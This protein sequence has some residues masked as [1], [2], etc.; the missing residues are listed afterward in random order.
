MTNL[1]QL[2]HDD[3]K[4]L[5]STR[6]ATI[7]SAGQYAIKVLSKDFTVEPHNP[8]FELSILARLSKKRDPHVIQLIDSRS[9]DDELE[10]LFPRY[11]MDLNE[12]MRRDYK[13]SFSTVNPYYTLAT[14]SAAQSEGGYRNK[15]DV[16]RYALDFTLQLARGLEF[17]HLNDIIHRDIKPQN[18]LVAKDRRD[19]I[20]LIITDFGIS[21]DCKDPQQLS[22]EP[23]DNKI[24]DVSTSVYKA[25]E[26]LFGVKNYTFAIDIWA[27]MV[28]ISQWFQT[29][30][31]NP[32]RHIPAMF[33]DG[34]GLF[35]DG[36]SGSDIKLIL[37]I[38]DQLGIPSIKEWPEVEQ[39][40][41]CDAF[42]GMFGSEGDSQYILNKP[43]D[44]KFKKIN[45]LLP[46][47]NEICDPKK[48][49]ALRSC[50]LGMMSFESSKRCTSG[51][52]VKTLSL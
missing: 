5:K 28:M 1:S 49:T 34:S 23:L 21:Y 4:L 40:G 38:F 13:P 39:N 26:L 8:N 45:N 20:A 29:K 3:R 18:I 27:L 9:V 48:R 42:C 25:P 52:I 17:L 51:D 47:L 30:T 14:K 7:Y 10:L 2:A 24:T 37:S 33:E 12:L 31:N 46:R 6:F 19:S 16:D 22:L 15:F 36:E 11:Q 43:E 41:S 44:D 50:I 35:D 32:S